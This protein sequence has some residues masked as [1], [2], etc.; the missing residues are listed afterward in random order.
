MSEGKSKYFDVGFGISSVSVS[1]TGDTIVATLGANYHGVSI[2]AGTTRVAVTV[3]DNAATTA[4]N[5]LD[6]FVVNAGGDFQRDKTIPVIA[7]N[8]IVVSVT[9]TGATGVIFFSPKG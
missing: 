3:Y 4:G 1:G 8:G 7:R 6:A 9:G 2:I 5:L